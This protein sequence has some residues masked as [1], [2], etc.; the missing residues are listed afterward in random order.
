M[1]IEFRKVVKEARYLDATKEFRETVLP[2]EIRIDPLTKKQGRVV[3]FRFKM[4]QRPDLSEMIEKSRPG[5]PFCPEN[6]ERLTPQFPKKFSDSGRIKVGEAI[7]FPNSM[8]YASYN[9]IVLFSGDHFIEIDDFDEELIVNSLLVC[10]EYLK[11]VWSYE[12]EVRYHSINWNYMPLA[13]AGLIHPHL[14]IIASD[15]PTNYHEQL[16]DKSRDYY[17]KTGRNFWEDLITKEKALQERYV[18]NTGI[19]HW[20]TSFVPKGMM[21]D[22]M[23]VFSQKDS[24][25]DLRQTELEDFSRGLKK[26]LSYLGEQNFYSFN[27]TIYSGL[28]NQSYFWNHARI[29]SRF[30]IPPAGTS[31]VNYLEKLHEEVFIVKSPED[32]C[33]E[34]KVRF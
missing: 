21:L 17:E 32:V 30:I 3:N 5:C 28:P 13:G 27:M 14:Q 31:D 6:V 19:V 2:I 24:L 25:L 7:A 18:G 22:V 12:P 9:G 15:I 33:K 23:A 34:L 4:P 10:Q 26:V 16:M 11:K 29:V 8:P 20:L 1:E